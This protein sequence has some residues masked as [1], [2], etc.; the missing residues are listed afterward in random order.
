VI[1]ITVIEL[2]RNRSIIGGPR[3]MSRK[4]PYLVLSLFVIASVLSGCVSSKKYK[5]LEER[6]EKLK[7]G[8]NNA[9]K[10]LDDKDLLI[11]QLQA[12]LQVQRETSER[13]TLLLKQ[14]Q[15]ALFETLNKE[16]EDM[17]VQI[18]QIQNRLVVS[19]AEELFFDTGKAE[20]KSD[21]KRVLRRIGAVLKKIPEKNIRIEGHTDTVP[22]GRALRAQYPTNWELGTARAVNV[23]RYLQEEGGLDPLR[24]SAVSYGQYR[25]ISSN[26]TAAGR[27]KNRR[28]EIT[29]VDRDLDLAKKMRENLKP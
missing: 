11:E 20:I 21:G 24:L 5:S 9:N 4:I 22:I 25:P 3:T 7:T 6:H 8:F 14:T 13:D 28:I 26:R 18:N 27:A 15:N 16:I 23:V 19:V 17:S 1:N 2:K 10:Q 29:L 12:E